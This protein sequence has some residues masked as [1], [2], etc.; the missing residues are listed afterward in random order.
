MK[1]F[2]SI[3]IL[4]NSFIFSSPISEERAMDV[5][6][7][8]FFYRNNPNSSEFIIETSEINTVKNKKIF[9][10]IKL[11]PQGFILI[12]A[13]NLIRPILAYSFENDYINEN[14]PVNIEYIFNLYT[15]ELLEQEES[16]NTPMEEILDEW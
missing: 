9:Y 14:I 3:I 7:N 12:R 13:D 6:E 2:I 15:E 10:I 8:F 1:K 16:R 4:I 11:N 5:A